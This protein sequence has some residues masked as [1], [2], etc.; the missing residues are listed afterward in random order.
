[1][2]QPDM[3]IVENNVHPYKDSVVMGRMK[4]PSISKYS[5]LANKY[6]G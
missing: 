2:K 6:I 3:V 4:L 1:M 5:W